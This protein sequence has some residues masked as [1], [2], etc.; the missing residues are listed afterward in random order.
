Q[1][2]VQTT[3]PVDYS[4]RVFGAIQ[5]A[6]TLASILGMAGGGMLAEWIGVSLA[7]LVCGCLLIL[8]GLITL[9]GK[10]VSESRRYLVTK[11]N[12][13]AQG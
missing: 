5:S 8:I 3:V 2:L 7:F 6:T 13:G 9:V 1:I 11:S 10:K 4:G 12:K